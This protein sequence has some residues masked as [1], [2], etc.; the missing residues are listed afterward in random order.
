MEEE[1]EGQG[2][3]GV[4]REHRRRMVVISFAALPYQKRHLAELALT[5]K[6]SQS[7][8]AREGL[9]FL[10]AEYAKMGY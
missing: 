10:F 8:L 1:T 5:A 4:K 6:K 7:E 3:E 2:P 9:S